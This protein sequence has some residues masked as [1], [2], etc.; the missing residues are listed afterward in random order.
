MDAIRLAPALTPFGALGLDRL[1][2]LGGG[3]RRTGLLYRLW[4]Q[5][6]FDLLAFAGMSKASGTRCSAASTAASVLIL[7][8]AA[9]IAF[10]VW[11]SGRADRSWGK[12]A[13]GTAPPLHEIREAVLA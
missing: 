5:A 4:V 12:F 2:R 1:G 9:W 10:W 13:Y 11:I 8:M 3:P 7:N 6:A